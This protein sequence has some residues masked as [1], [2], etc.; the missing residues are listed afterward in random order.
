MPRL[1]TCWNRAST[2]SRSPVAYLQTLV[3][4]DGSVRYSATGAQTPVWV[5]AQALT[6]IARKPLP[7]VP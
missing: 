7:V 3:M 1:I 4:P 6:G 2:G 5:T